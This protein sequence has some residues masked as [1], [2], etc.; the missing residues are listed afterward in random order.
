MELTINIREVS[1]INFILELMQ[2]FDYID[3]LNKSELSE[4]TQQQQLEIDQRLNKLEKGKSELHSW[5]EVKDEI[6][7][8]L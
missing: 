7:S 3:V 6:Y 4:F 5:S 8:D 1:K 2:S